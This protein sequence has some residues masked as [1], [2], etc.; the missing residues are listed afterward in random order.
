MIGALLLVQLFF[1]IHYV[2]AKMV[3]S[4]VS[5]AAWILVRVGVAA[6]IWLS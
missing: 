3:V 5:P 2:A 1:G 6:L 4:W